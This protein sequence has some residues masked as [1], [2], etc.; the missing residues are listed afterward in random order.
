MAQ[1]DGL[2]GACTAESRPKKGAPGLPAG[3]SLAP[4][5]AR[6]AATAPD[7]FFTVTGSAHA[8]HATL[9]FGRQVER[10]ALKRAVR[11]VRRH[12]SVRDHDRWYARP[13]QSPPMS[14]APDDN[15]YSLERR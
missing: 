11:F 9:H 13:A 14:R 3:S 15:G 12:A 4:L 5:R 10:N 1:M 2:D 6:G 7:V 8:W